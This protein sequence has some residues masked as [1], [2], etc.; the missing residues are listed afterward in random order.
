[1]ILPVEM[2]VE[3]LR[4]IMRNNGK[5]HVPTVGEVLK[6]DITDIQYTVTRYKP[7][8]TKEINKAAM[9]SAAIF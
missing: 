4:R 5:Q 8:K 7:S 2:P 1:M 6:E 9:W 3:T